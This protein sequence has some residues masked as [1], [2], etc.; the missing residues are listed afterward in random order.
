MSN[1]EENDGNGASVTLIGN[2]MRDIDNNSTAL[3]IP[4]EFAKELD[5][6]NSKVSMSLLDDFQGNRH[7]VVSK[8]YKEIAIE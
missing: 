1:I 4:K 8:Y 7:L 2:T 5:I 3:I 6:E